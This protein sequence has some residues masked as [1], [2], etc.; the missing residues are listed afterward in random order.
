M[1][2]IAVNQCECRNGPVWRVCA[3]PTKLHWAL[4]SDA[5]A[6]G[7]RSKGVAPGQPE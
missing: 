3:G 6:G 7:D 2:S 4:G 5:R 1:D